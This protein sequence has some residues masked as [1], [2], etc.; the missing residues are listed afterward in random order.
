MQTDGYAGYNVACQKY[1]LTHVGCMGHARRMFV[2][3][4]KALPC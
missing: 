2:E 1:G 3:V 4:Q